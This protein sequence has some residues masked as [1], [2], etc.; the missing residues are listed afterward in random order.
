MINNENLLCSFLSRLEKE[1]TKNDYERDIKNFTKFLGKDFVH[2]TSNDCERYVDYLKGE[3]LE[4]RI[5]IST[6]EKLYSE[7]YSFYNY[8]EENSY[9]TYNYFKN[10][11]KP[12]AT[13]NIA[14]EK[15]ISW[16]EFDQ[17]IS[18][19]KTYHSRD[20]AILLLI[21]TSGLT[22]SEAVN[23]KWNRF[24]IDNKGNTGII[25]ITKR[26]RRYV[27]VHKDVWGLLER[28]RG[29]LSKMV[30]QDNYVF[31][32][33]RGNKISG[34][35]VRLVLKKACNEAKLDREYTP[36]DLRHTLAAYAL[37]KG[38][39]SRQV[40]EQLGWSNESLA[41]RYLYTIQQLEENAI[42]Y[43]NFHLK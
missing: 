7:I 29:S 23:L 19:L 36:R 33:N 3:I 5:A 15:I 22:L 11:S 17:L 41:E 10:I 28:Y 14:K 1:K 40:Q 9:I 43:L 21:F 31:L 18:V 32:N 12:V 34:R 42:D 13:R 8:L 39:S 25:F 6:A 35:W 16:E 26:G 24:F 4:K 27:K 30:S 38:A 20:F 2:V 37:K